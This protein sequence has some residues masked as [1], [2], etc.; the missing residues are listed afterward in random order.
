MKK[1]VQSIFVLLLLGTGSLVAQNPGLTELT[2]AESG[3][4]QSLDASND[5][6]FGAD[7]LATQFFVMNVANP[8]TAGYEVTVTNSLILVNDGLAILQSNLAAAAQ[9][10]SSNDISQ[11]TARVATI[12]S[13]YADFQVESD[14]FVKRVNK[15][16][17][18]PAQIAYQRLRDDLLQIIQL[19]EEIVAN[20]RAFYD[21]Y[22][23]FNVRIRLVD[24]N[25][26]EIP[27]SNTGLQGFGAEDVNSNAVFFT[28]PWGA[29]TE[30]IGIP[31]GTYRFSAFNGPFDGASSKVV[32]LSVFLEGADGFIEVT[33][34]YF[35]E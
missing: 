13:L 8:N 29:P 34:N 14:R 30:F 1:F 19:H 22:G 17:T 23:P 3:A 6:L 4:E 12:Q 28:D 31:A 10:N 15:G 27:Y 33:L 35:S 32:T 9:V 18:Q 21:S 26:N 25:N 5:I 16:Q 2:T 20:F 7:Q 11:V 24:S